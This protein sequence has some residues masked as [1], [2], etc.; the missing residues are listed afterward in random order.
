MIH[1][2][3]MLTSYPGFQKPGYNTWS[4]TIENQE[5]GAREKLNIN[6]VGLEQ[7]E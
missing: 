4:T 2:L 7:R 5:R 6:T 3:S 1:F